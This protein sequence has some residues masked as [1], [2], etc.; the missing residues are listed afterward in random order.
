MRCPFPPFLAHPTIAR[1]KGQARSEGDT[2]SLLRGTRPKLVALAVGAVALIGATA[3]YAAL[4]A[5]DTTTG[6]GA[7][8]HENGGDYNTADGQNALFSNTDGMNNAAVGA[9]ALSANVHAI[10]NAA[11]GSFALDDN[12]GSYNTGLG[13][14]ALADNT[15]GTDNTAVGQD[16]GDGATPNTTGSNNTFVGME[17]LPGGVSQINNAT[18]IGAHSVVSQSN[19]MVLGADGVNV[20]VDT[21]AP[22]SRIQIGTGPTSL[23]GDY[24]QIP[25][26][27]NTDKTPPAADCNNS[28]FVGRMVWQQ[29]KKKLVLWGCSSQ[30]V[31]TRG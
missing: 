13:N 8:S 17:A 19:P 10:A 21:S 7:L 9:Y 1:R 3:A 26:V 6:T 4:G 28:T 16:A 2:K 29:V 24:M 12:L 25:V 15:T 14:I 31:W 22:Q 11:L 23:W 18:A 30:G 20:G 5:N 27:I